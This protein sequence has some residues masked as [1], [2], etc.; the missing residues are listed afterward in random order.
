MAMT[1]V[2]AL[3]STKANGRNRHPPSDIAMIAFP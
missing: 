1:K 3:A 2:A